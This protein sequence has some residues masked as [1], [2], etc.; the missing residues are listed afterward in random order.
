[1][2]ACVLASGSSGNSTFISADNH[3]ILIDVGTNYKNLDDKLNEIGYKLSDI[4]YIFISHAHSDHINSLP[5]IIKK[6]NPII[7]VSEVMLNSIPSLKGYNNL[8]LYDN[9]LKIDQIKIDYIKT[10]HDSPDSRGFI[11]TYNEKSL[12]YIT[13]TGYI[14]AKY[15]ETLKNKELYIMESNH[16]PEMLIN[17][18]Y[19]KWLQA[20]ILSDVGHLSNESSSLY[21]SKLIGP[22]TKKIIL[23]HLS[24]QNNSEEK[25]LEVFQKMMFDY[26]INFSGVVI[27]KPDQRTELFEL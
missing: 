18:K 1:M 23:A 22:K 16:D 4:D 17:G 11:V 8:L 24:E 15:F 6:H 3:Q 10:S 14:N 20:R 9:S 5:Q 7:C 12:V 13:D 2:K 21:L 27:A 19:P 26:E 25:A